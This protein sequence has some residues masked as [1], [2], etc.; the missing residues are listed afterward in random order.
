MRSQ[1]VEAIPLYSTS[2]LNLATTFLFLLIQEFKLSLMETQY[3]EVDLLSEGKL[4]QS[5]LEYYRTWYY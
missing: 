4:A 2:T 5:T 1:E 3:L